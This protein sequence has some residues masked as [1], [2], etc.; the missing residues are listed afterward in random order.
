MAFD[1]IGIDNENEFYPA[2]FLSDALEDELRAALACWREGE[3]TP[4]NLPDT[5][6][7]AFGA[8]YLRGLER[9]RTASSLQDMRS[10]QQSLAS[11]LVRAL[12][13]G[14]ERDTL[15][16]NDGL[17]VPVLARSTDRNGRDQ[18]WIVEAPCVGREDEGADPLTLEFDPE[19]FTESDRANALLGT[20]IDAVLTESIFALDA[21]PRYVIVVGLTQA[22]LVDRVKWPTRSVLRFDLPELFKRA[23]QTTLE[24]TACLLSKEARAPDSG[25]PLAER[26]EEEAQRH[27][28]A[29]T[30]SLK[31]TVR[32]AIE[33]LGN[34]VLAVTGGKYPSGKRKGVWIDSQDLTIECL[35]Y[36]YRL[37]FLFYAEANPR[38]GII[39]LKDPVYLS[40]YSLEALR[41][42]EMRKLR[43]EE[44]R[45]GTFLWESLQRLLGLMYEGMDRRQLGATR[46]FTLPRVRVS[47]LDPE[48]TPIL[49]KIS[50]RNE[51]V[52]KIIRLL[53]LKRDKAGSGR[54]SYAQ[55]GIGQLGAV[56]ET[57][58]SFTGFV[59]K[60][61]MIELIPPKGKKAAADDDGETV[62]SE[63]DADDVLDIEPESDAESGSINDAAVSRSDK[64]DLLAP[65]YFVSRGRSEEFKREEIVYDG[66]Q[67]RIYPKGKFIYRL[68]GRDRQKS[69]SYYTPEPLARLL[70]KHALIERCKEMSADEIL[71]LKVLEPAMG[72]AAFLVETTNQLADL[73]LERKQTEVSQRIP[74]DRYFE[75]RQKVRAYIADRNCFGV[76]L[77]PIAVELGQISLWLNGLHSSDF[78]PWFGDQ[79]H[80]GNSLIGARRAA[81][82]ARLLTAKKTD[83]LW[84]NNIPTEIGWRGAREPNLIWQFLLPAADMAKFDTDKSIAAFAGEAQKTIKAWRKGG[85]FAPFETHEVK[86]LLDLSTAVDELFDAVAEDLTASRIAANDEITIWPKRIMPGAKNTDFRAKLAR[87]KV[88]QGEEHVSN[89]LPYQ[90]LKTVMDAWCA[91]WLWP[92]DQTHLLPSRNEYLLG[93]QAILKG[94]ITDSGDIEVPDDDAFAAPQVDLLTRQERANQLAAALPSRGKQ[95]SMFQPTNIDALI[96]SSPWLQAARDVAQRE[97]FVHFDLAFAD[98]L[99]ERGGFDVIVGNPPW[100][101]PSWNEGLILADLDP[102]HMG[103]SA[104]EAKKTLELS[105]AKTGR[106]QDFLSAFVSTRGAIAVTSSPAMNPFAGGGQN[107]LY[108][109]FIDLSFRVSAERGIVA[110]VHQDGHLSDPNAGLFRA[111][112]YSRIRRHYEFSNKITTKNFAEVEDQKRFSLNI[113]GSPRETTTFV[114]FHNAFVASQVED[115]LQPDAP[116][117]HSGIRDFAGHW[118]IRGDAARVVRVEDSYLSSLAK[119]TGEEHPRSTAFVPPFSQRMLPVFDILA[120]LPSLSSA[121]VRW[122]M[123]RLWEESKRQKDGTISKAKEFRTAESTVLQ[124]PMFYVGNPFNKSA[125]LRGFGNADYDVVDLVEL[126][127]DYLPR[128]NFGRCASSAEYLQRVPA[129]EWDHTRKHTDFYRLAARKRVPVNSERSLVACII[130]PA[131]GHVDQIQSVSFAKSRDLAQL[132]A[133]AVALPNDFLMKASGRS[134][135][136]DSDLGRFRWVDPGATALHRGLRLACL[137][138]DYADIWNE[139]SA[140]LT[141]LSWSSNDPRLATEGP[142]HGPDS[143]DRTA[144]FRTEFARRMALIEIDVL[145]AQALGLSLDQ[146]IDIYEIY[147]PVMRE[148]EAGTWFDQTGRIVWTCSKGLPGVG[149]LLNGRSP[150]RKTWESLVAEAPA[151]LEC[152][153]VDDT[154]PGGPRK[155]I[156]RFIGPFTQHDRVE[157]YRHAWAHFE[158]LKAEGGS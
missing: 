10:I 154:Q 114:N 136:M 147:F 90:R 1:L 143:W 44:D 112:W 144:G 22:V 41:G 81:Y 32:D 74:Q 21:P 128:S 86:L 50:L 141:P 125:K 36:M 118:E 7:T 93:L 85:F 78:S 88:L 20:P 58:I 61:D 79:L 142:V 134:D 111:S 59:A 97:R 89:S 145:V 139:L 35:R 45:K 19:Q 9:V 123:R 14:A 11:D 66:P 54:I 91:L 16:T 12:G 83:D 76:D 105:L 133:L 104:S 101:K 157:D 92:L 63:S 3:A 75:E 28:N 51:A 99:R 25:V 121:N 130:P 52:Q 40:G 57:L 62:E 42:L 18:A 116:T 29:V 100:S 137:T 70:V 107:N 8:V 158:R 155:I 67:P 94:G 80:A 129:C 96:A 38:L 153:A 64:V 65:S 72:S 124:G 146:L 30:T 53:S 77:N 48:S 151:K 71:E 102:R 56:Y 109:C 13:F 98:V 5:R 103:A 33:F 156:R 113:Y 138:E 24:A 152:E 82:D 140:D 46:S 120:Q 17:L 117:I 68:A 148:N 27:A 95:S 6:L 131:I 60:T 39:P 127:A 23:E 115:S 108:R 69:A 122:Q 73:Y 2:A 47:L 34:E 31:K 55:L 150:G 106:Q 149:Y 26:L 37:L 84:L 110:L 4:A 119:I 15:A 135:F 43:T 126:S 49:S 132:H 87:L